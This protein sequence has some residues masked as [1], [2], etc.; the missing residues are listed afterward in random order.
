MLASVC[1]SVATHLCSFSDLHTTRSKAPSLL[2]KF[3]KRKDPMMG[4][5]S[6]K[7]PLLVDNML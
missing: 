2:L 1:S 3:T 5:E 4:E 7:L 6:A